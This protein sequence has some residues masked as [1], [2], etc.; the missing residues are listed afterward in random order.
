MNRRLIAALLSYT[1]GR[2]RVAPEKLPPEQPGRHVLRGS[3]GGAD[4]IS[5]EAR[6]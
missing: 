5:V 2:P 3:T 6:R 1:P 4:A